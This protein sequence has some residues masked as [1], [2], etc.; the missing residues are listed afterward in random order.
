MFS[1]SSAQALWPILL[2][3]LPWTHA[4]GHG[5]ASWSK[6]TGGSTAD[7]ASASSWGIQWP[8]LWCRESSCKSSRL[9]STPPW[10]TTSRTLGS[11]ALHSD[12]WRMMLVLAVSPDSSTGPRSPLAQWRCS[13]LAPHPC[14]TGRPAGC[15]GT[16]KHGASLGLPASRSW[17]HVTCVTRPSAEQGEEPT[18][19]ASPPNRLAAPV[20]SHR[21]DYHKWRNELLTAHYPHIVRG[22]PALAPMRE[23]G[24]KWT[25]QLQLHGTNASARVRS[26]G[27]I[28][29]RAISQGQARLRDHP[30]QQLRWHCAA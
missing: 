16:L 8:S 17:I 15:S 26:D 19:T 6:A 11:Q 30:S 25:G 9:S 1:I 14:P 7:A 29:S 28:S 5:R 3:R 2:G 24:L 4:I 20:G 21:D 12:P 18:C 13:V 10:P 22:Q 23:S 27:L